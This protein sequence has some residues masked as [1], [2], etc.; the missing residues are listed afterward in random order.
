[1][2]SSRRGGRVVRQRPAKPRTPVRL[3]SAPFSALLLLLGFAAAARLTLSGVLVF[4]DAT[5][6]NG[7]YG[8]NDDQTQYYAFAEAMT[9]GVLAPVYTTIGYDI[10]LLPFAAV[11][12]FVLQAIPAVAAVQIALGL[13]AAVLLY[14]VGCEAMSRWAAAVGTALWLALALVLGPLFKSSLGF[15]RSHAPTWVGLNIGTDY[16]SSLD[17]KSVV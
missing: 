9:R 12:D 4:T 3:R 6:H 10:L 11:T 2:I 15:W 5:D 14:R 8:P 13:A 17:R 1:M 7:W 16:A